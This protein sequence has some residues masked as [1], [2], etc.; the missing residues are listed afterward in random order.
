[1]KRISLLSI[2]LVVALATWPASSAREKTRVE[3]PVDWAGNLSPITAG[4]WNY[5]R[6]R[7]LL[8]RTGFGGTP[9]EVERLAA[10]SPSQA[11]DYLLDYEKLDDSN[12][13]KFDPSN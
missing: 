2:A 12:F 13:P 3:S 8:E 7:H 5:D 11:V 6:A 4:D 10:M 9:E 1:M